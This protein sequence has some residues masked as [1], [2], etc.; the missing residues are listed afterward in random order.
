MT[1]LI[2]EMRRVVQEHDSMREAAFNLWSWLPSHLFAEEAHGDYA[3]EVGQPS[4][5]EIIEEAM[6][7]LS[8]TAGYDLDLSSDEARALFTCACEECQQRP[9]TAK[10]IK[11]VLLKF[12]EDRREKK[13]MTTTYRVVCSEP[14]GLTFDVQCDLS[15]PSASI[16]VDGL[17]TGSQTSNASHQTEEAI[18]IAYEYIA[19]EDPHAPCWDDVECE[20]QTLEG[21]DVGVKGR[22]D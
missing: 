16:L 17:L 2:D 4:V 21:D 6:K 10:A 19:R 20:W 8:Y 7:V 12:R 14:V 9:P 13:S 1:T 3:A 11:T 18:R 15:Q 22:E 5:T